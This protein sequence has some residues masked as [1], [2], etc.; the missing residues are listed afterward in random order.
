MTFDFSNYK[1]NLYSKKMDRLNQLKIK[2]FND[3]ITDEELVEMDNI[4][5]WIRKYS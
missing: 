1:D 2:N 4:F 3:N 5:E